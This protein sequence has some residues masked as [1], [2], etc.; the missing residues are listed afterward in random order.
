M[1]RF[2]LSLAVAGVLGFQLGA[3]PA[4]APDR[5][6]P[7]PSGGILEG[8]PGRVIG[9]AE[10]ATIRGGDVVIKLNAAR[11]KLIVDVYIN[12]DELRRLSPKP[13]KTL[14]LDAHNRPVDTT[15]APFMPADRDVLPLGGALTSK[16]AKFPAGTCKVTSVQEREGSYGPYMVKTGAVGEVNVYAGDKLLGKYKDVGYAIHS[17]NIKFEYSQSYG[18]IIIRKEDNAKLAKILKDDRKDALDREDRKGRVTQLVHVE[19]E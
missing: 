2:L 13:I 17:N 3:L 12:D 19:P 7:P 18:C 6:S 5:D 9:P 15:K 14:V 10:A 8:L 16:P 1:K 4:A 11:T